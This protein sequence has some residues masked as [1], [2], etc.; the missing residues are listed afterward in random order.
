MGLLVHTT[1]ETSHGITIQNVYV[2][3]SSITVDFVDVSRV[4]IKCE[5]HVNREKRL[6]GKQPLYVPNIPTYF[7]IETPNWNNIQY[8]YTQVKSQLTEIGFE[9]IED[10]FESN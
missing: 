8:L 1:F 4:T 10:V 7:N 2:R 6:E 5:S 9:N 3:I